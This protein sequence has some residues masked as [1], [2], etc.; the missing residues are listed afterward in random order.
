ME[1][2]APD[3]FDSTTARSLRLAQSARGLK[4]TVVWKGQLSGNPTIQSCGFVSNF[5]E[6]FG[7]NTD[8]AALAS[9]LLEQSAVQETYA[10]SASKIF[11]H[12]GMPL[13]FKNH[14]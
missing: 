1:A 3:V 4:S 9:V 2:K 6:R 12:S 11:C 8:P 10:S 5:G 7:I 13:I 14:V